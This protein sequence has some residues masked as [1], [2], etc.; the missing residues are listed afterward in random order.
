M[1]KKKIA[2]FICVAVVLLL[3]AMMAVALPIGTYLYSKALEES[4]NHV[5]LDRSQT[6]T[7][8]RR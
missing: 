8:G 4:D 5:I 2:D 6:Q 1:H 3:I 7:I